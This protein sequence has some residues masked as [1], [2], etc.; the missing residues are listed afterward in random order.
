VARYYAKMIDGQTGGEGSYQFDG[1]DNLMSLTADEIVSTF[2]DHVERD[3]L[4]RHSDWELNSVMKNKP[5]RVVTALGSLVP[6]NGGDP[7]P[8]LLMISER[9]A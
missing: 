3:V 8:F 5:L 1:A 4:Q 7:S 6:A 2:F 9:K